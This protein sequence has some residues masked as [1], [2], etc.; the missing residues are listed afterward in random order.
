MG[1]LLSELPQLSSIITQALCSS[2]AG[3]RLLQ[4]HAVW[5]INGTREGLRTRHFLSNESSI[6]HNAPRNTRLP[7]AP[8]DHEIMSTKPGPA[9]GLPVFAPPPLL[10]LLAGSAHIHTHT[11]AEIASGTLTRLAQAFPG[12]IEVP[13]VNLPCRNHPAS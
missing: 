11:A 8:S 13:A 4:K 12:S 2:Q 7:R 5:I 3:R 1:P 9:R 6:I 10:T